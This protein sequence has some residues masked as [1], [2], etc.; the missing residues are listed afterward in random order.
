MGGVAPGEAALDAGMAVVGLAVLVRHHAHDFVAV[1]LRL[2]RAADA[3][4]GAGGDHRMLG[5]ADLD[6]RLSRS[7]SRSGRP[8]RRRRRRRIRSRGTARPCPATPCESK[9]RP[10]MVSAK[11]PC[12]SSQARTQREQTMHF[13]GIEGEIG[14]GLVLAPDRDDWRRRSRSALRA[15]RPRRP[16]PAVRSRRWPAQVRQSSGWSEM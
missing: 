14:I 4:I 9:P 1:H 15:G 11:V 5:L 6:D 12:T 13:A 8:A 16:C 10:S 2:E 7:A 3:A